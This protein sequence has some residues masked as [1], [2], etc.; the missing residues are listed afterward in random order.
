M[1]GPLN[2]KL[3]T[4]VFPN[5]ILPALATSMRTARLAHPPDLFLKTENLKLW[6]HARLKKKRDFQGMDLYGETIFEK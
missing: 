5:K 3:F 2:V 1:H 6:S 4:S